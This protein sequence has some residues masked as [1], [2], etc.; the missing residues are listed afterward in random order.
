[1]GSYNK[2]LDHKLLHL[3]PLSKHNISCSSRATSLSLPKTALKLK[4][5][6][7]RF[8]SDFFV[9]ARLL[10]LRYV[11]MDIKGCCG[12]GGASRTTCALSLSSETL[13]WVFTGAAALLM[14]LRNTAMKKSFLVPMLALQAPQEVITW[15]RGEYGIWAA[16]LALLVRLFY[17][18]PGELELPLVFV[19]LVITAPYQAMDLRGT[20]AAMVTCAGVAAFL[21]YQHFSGAG[22]L[23]GSFKESTFLASLAVVCLVAVPFAFL[24]GAV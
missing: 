5:D 23:K 15:I 6:S 20:T 21:A 4:K 7:P 10:K 22:G 14:L 3:A 2:L 8:T 19:L 16:F 13:R 17:Y 12:Y 11:V 24:L 18:I 9:D 1:M